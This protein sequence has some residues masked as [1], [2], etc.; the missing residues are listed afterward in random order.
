MTT[1]NE[2]TELPRFSA[3]LRDATWQDHEQAESSAF[4]TA[5]M[6]GD[7]PID[8]YADL[9]AQQ[10][11]VYAVLE[12]AAESQ[13]A[14]AIAAPFVFDELTRLPAIEADL[15]HLLGDDWMSR[16]EPL[17]ATNAYCDRIRAVCFDDP[18][19]FVAHHY[20]RYLGDLSG[21]QF[22]GRVV[23][24]VYELDDERGAAFFAFTAIDDPK[25]FKDTYRARLDAAPWSPDE[26]D[27][28]IAEIRN[29]YRLNRDVFAD[30]DSTLP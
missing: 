30:L 26:Q 27:A 4:V 19:A 1:T 16:I 18:G 21:G 10:W 20:T 13:R 8:G 22:I 24:R 12:A 7:L 2:T 6:A 15:A 14:D 29:A 17:P 5:L 25:A 28:V 3:A 23:K 11:F 9:A